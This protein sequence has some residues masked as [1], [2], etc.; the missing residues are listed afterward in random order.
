MENFNDLVDSFLKVAKGEK[1]DPGEKGE[2]GEPGEQGEK[3]NVGIGIRGLKGDTFTYGDMS[4]DDKADLVDIS[5]GQWDQPFAEKYDKLEQEYAE[6][7]TGVKTQLADIVQQTD[8][9]GVN[10]SDKTYTDAQLALKRD[11]SVKITTD[12]IDK[13]TDAKKIHLLD[14]S[15]EVQAAMAGTAPVIGSVADG[16]IT[17]SKYADQSVTYQKLKF[18]Y[19][20][21]IQEGK[22]I[23]N[24]QTKKITVLSTFINAGNSTYVVP[25]QTIDFSA[26]YVNGTFFCYFD[27]ADNTVKCA[28]LSSLTSGNLLI[29]LSYA[30]AIF[31]INESRLKLVNSSGKAVSPTKV[32]IDENSLPNSK[33]ELNWGTIIQK[34]KITLN[35]ATKKISIATCWATSTTSLV[36]IPA[37]TIDLSSYV[38]STYYCYLNMTSN[39]VIFSASKPP[40]NSLILFIFFDWEIFGWNEAAITVINENGTNDKALVKTL[41]EPF[42]ELKDRMILP[43]D[44]YFLTEK[45]LPIYKSSIL[46]RDNFN[47]KIKLALITDNA[48]GDIDINYIYDD[49]LLDS[50]KLANIF[51]IN[52]TQSNNRGYNYYKNINKHAVSKSTLNGKAFKMLNIGDSLTANDVA[53]MLKDKLVT[54]GVTVTMTGTISTATALNSEG[55]GSWT[56]NHFVGKSSKFGST[57]VSRVTDGVS[58]TTNNENPFLKLATEEDKTNNPDWCFRHSPSPGVDV[59][60]SYS[61]DTDKTGDFYIFDFAWYISSR[62][63][64][65]PDIVT[66]AL[67]T[68]DSLVQEMRFGLDLMIK[69]IKS[70]VP[71]VKIGVIPQPA[72]GTNTTG[73]NAWVNSRAEWVENAITDINTLKATYNDLYIIPAWCH[74]NRDFNF[75]YTGN[76]NLSSVSTVQKAPRVENI[77]FNRWGKLQ[78]INAVTAF[79]ANVM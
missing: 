43:D 10:K 13:S 70:A 16:S 4:E 57:Y 36:S 24:F 1:G 56:F 19:G 18:N 17:T 21:L 60:L 38:G 76:I 32:I 66:I 53:V 65:T 47:D 58:S 78:Y 39:I 62:G 6:D 29:F 54:L 67:G 79:L 3:G 64:E 61:E 68:N 25:A 42:D 27:Q 40:V 30:D 26:I 9:L 41:L 63:L 33:L 8:S 72:R 55:R 52:Q 11:K 49:F 77:H 37:T 74:M 23:V 20:I 71:T 12:D 2:R 75:D 34:D 73:Y 46:A 59:E 14:L 51:K 15:E 69:Q 5:T 31:G 35:L 50:S 45:P 48:D 28:N 22:I 7:L 44:M